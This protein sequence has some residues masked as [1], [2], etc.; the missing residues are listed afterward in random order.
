[1]EFAKQAGYETVDDLRTKLEERLSEAA[2][3][4]SNSVA[5]AQAMSAVIEASTYEIP[6]SMIE[7]VAEDLYQDEVRRMLSMRVPIDQITE[8]DSELRERSQEGA[9][10]EIKRLVTLNEI[11]EAEG[12]EVTE[13]DFEQEV[14][15]IASRTGAAMEAVSS[16]LEEGDRRGSYEARLMRSKALKVIMD[17]ANVT[18]KEVSREEMAES[19]NSNEGDDA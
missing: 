19:E 4:Q 5:E 9:V 16:Y 18:E 13:D 15:A 10:N 17:A 1:D 7:G 8:N 6:K 11:A 12:V 14:Q 2:S 3:G